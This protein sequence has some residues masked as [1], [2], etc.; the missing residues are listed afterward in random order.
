MLPTLNEGMLFD[1]VLLR[2]RNVPHFQTYNF[3]A[4]LTPEKSGMVWLTAWVFTA[5]VL[6]GGREN[7]IKTWVWSCHKFSPIF[8]LS[9]S[10]K[11]HFAIVC[12]FCS[13][14]KSLQWPPPSFLLFRHCRRLLSGD[15]VNPFHQPI[16]LETWQEFPNVINILLRHDFQDRA[17]H[18]GAKVGKNESRLS[19]VSLCKAFFEI[20]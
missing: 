7:I 1:V 2:W 17:R 20:S 12:G 4:G 6:N 18:A 14:K 5:M 11:C 13:V 10:C 9:G 8:G 3:M 15:A 16:K 19:A